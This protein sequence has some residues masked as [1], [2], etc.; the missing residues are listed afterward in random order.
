MACEQVILE[1][2]VGYDEE[3]DLASTVPPESDLPKPGKQWPPQDLPEQYRALLLEYKDIFMD[4]LP[5]D[6]TKLSTLLRMDVHVKDSFTRITN[7]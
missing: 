4:T 7:C 6:L 2:K 3:A 1:I 5:K